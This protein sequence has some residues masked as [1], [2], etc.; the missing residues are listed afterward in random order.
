M[1]WKALLLI[2]GLF[3][4]VLMLDARRGG[5]GSSS[6]GEASRKRA[7]A[8]AI[9]DDEKVRATAPASAAEWKKAIDLATLD[10]AEKRAG[11]AK[12][13][14]LEARQT[15]AGYMQLNPAP[16]E[17]VEQET[18]SQAL[19]DQVS[20]IENAPAKLARIDVLRK[21]AKES[22]RSQE[23]E[24]ALEDIDG[25]LGLVVELDKLPPGYLTMSLKPITA[26]LAKLRGQVQPKKTAD[27]RHADAVAARCG[28]RPQCGGGWDGEC[29]GLESA[30][31]RTAHDPDS[32]DVENC[33]EAQLTE[34]AC[35]VTTCDVR[36]KNMMGA[37]ILKRQRF[38]KSR[39]GWLNL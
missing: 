32:I 30:I 39:L 7:V 24:T 8:R 29:I 12:A 37:K 5:G 16:P 34:K 22:A 14:L 31:K 17:I 36:G 9:A 3:A 2:V 27:D 28:E 4:V 26:E 20:T 10:L 21:R 18:R 11:V 23:W 1:W 38:S 19:L 6:A 33:T 13:R 35:W 15:R 25:A